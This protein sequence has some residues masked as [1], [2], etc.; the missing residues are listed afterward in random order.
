VT[1]TQVRNE[2]PIPFHVCPLEGLEEAPAASHHFQEAAATVVIL[3]VVVE[4]APKVI[5]SGCQEGNLDRS[6]ASIL[7]V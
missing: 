3:L 1:E 7:F 4:V 2:P 5:D 6:A